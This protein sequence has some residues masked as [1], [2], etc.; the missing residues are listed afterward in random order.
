MDEY[1][2]KVGFWG[3]TVSEIEG[4][5]SEWCFG[6]IRKTKAPTN[7]ALG[8]ARKCEESLK[9][10]KNQNNYFLNCEDKNA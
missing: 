6:V 2:T 5:N 8:G 1:K 4:I 3:I 7:W 10:F 9:F